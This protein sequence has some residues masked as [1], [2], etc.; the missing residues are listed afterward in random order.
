MLLQ[1]PLRDEAG[2]FGGRLH[3]QRII[4]A[5]YRVM[6]EPRARVVHDIEGWA[7][8]RDVRRNIGYATITM[9]R[10]NRNMPY[11]WMARFGYFSI[12]LFFMA[13]L[14]NTWYLELRYHRQYDVAW[15]ELPVAFLVAIAIHVMELPGM[16]RAIRGNPLTE[17]AYR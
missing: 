4:D 1:H 14:A 2:P 17:T 11:A 8:E 16:V 7:M 3:A 5:G 12:P 10:L 6:F 9:R 15:Y 13:R